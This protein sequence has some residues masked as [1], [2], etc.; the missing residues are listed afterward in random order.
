MKKQKIDIKSEI[1]KIPGSQVEITGSIPAEA[2]DS[3]RP[4]AL[5]NINESISVDGFRKGSVPEKIVVAKVGEKTI[6]EETAELALSEI[7]PSLIID[8]KLDPIGRPEI[9]I[10]KMAAGNSLEFKIKVSLMPDI[11][12]AD[13]KKIAK[14]MPRVNEKELVVTEKDLSDAIDR[15]RKSYEN[16]E[17]HNH[18]ADEV[19]D[20]SEDIKKLET[21]EFKKHISDALA[22]DKKREAR[23]KRRIAIAD[24]ISIE[25]QIELPTAL[26]E[27]ETRRTEMQFQDDI[28]RMGY[29]LDQYLAQAK[30]TIEDLRKEWGPFA[31]KKV[32]LQLVLNKISEVEKISVDTKEIEKEVTHIMEHYKDADHDRAYSYAAGVL[33]NE[34]VFQF[35]EKLE[36]KD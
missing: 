33:T 6:L 25:S 20:H 3:F 7:Y 32:K 1:K 10:T 16:H 5:K 8:N 18:A 9:S 29:S 21:P 11:T 27:S 22:D 13:Y 17:G 31:E 15:I 23:E 12:L 36:N 4:K 34:K 28:A 30:K 35:R 2:F 14:D 26:I 19:H 24:K